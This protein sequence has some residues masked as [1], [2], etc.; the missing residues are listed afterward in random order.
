MKATDQLKE[1]HQGVRVM[2]S[3][4]EKIGQRL[5]SGEKVDPKHLEE[6]LEFIQVFV[7]KCHHGKEEELLIPALEENGSLKK[8]ILADHNEGRVFVSQL[9][10]AIEK[11]EKEEE[12]ASLE[13]VKAARGYS[14]FLETHIQFENETVFPFADKDLPEQKQEELFEGF[15]K[16][17]EEKIGVGKHEQFHKMLDE[18][19]KIYL[20]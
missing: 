2:L 20:S 18:F 5:E 15:E 1:E 16:I 3:I 9:A 12:D 10:E 11:Y 13:I 8:K 4:L 7:D 19:Q 17:E 6:I 14:Q